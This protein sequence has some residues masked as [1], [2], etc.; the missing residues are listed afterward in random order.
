[1]TQRMTDIPRKYLSDRSVV[2]EVAAFTRCAFKPGMAAQGILKRY[3]D[4]RTCKPC[5]ARRR[6][7][8]EYTRDWDRT[9]QWV[10]EYRER[11]MEPKRK[12]RR[13]TIH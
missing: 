5:L 6:I 13:R 4:S 3:C 9:D 10:R 8:E 2:F 1:M 12:P 7:D 11:W